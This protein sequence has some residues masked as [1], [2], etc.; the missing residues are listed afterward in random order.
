MGWPGPGPSARACWPAW[1]TPFGTGQHVRVISLTAGLAVLL[2]RDGP[3]ADAAT[4]HAT[5]VDAAQRVGDRL[6]EANALTDQGIVQRL[7]GEYPGA[8]KTLRQAMRT[9]RDLGDQLGQANVL[10]ELGAMRGMTGKFAGAA[11][12]LQKPWASTATSVTSPARR[13]PS[14]TSG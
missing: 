1:T 7:T 5:A 10:R 2:W 4:R 8:A 9:Y 6:G 11:K 14:S 13:T 3:W 12:T